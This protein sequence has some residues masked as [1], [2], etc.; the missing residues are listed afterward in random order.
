MSCPRINVYFTEA[1]V[2]QGR[3]KEASKPSKAVTIGHEGYN[4]FL[5]II[6]S[7]VRKQAFKKGGN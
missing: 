3:K 1:F 2:G 7:N 4:S 6:T 5:I